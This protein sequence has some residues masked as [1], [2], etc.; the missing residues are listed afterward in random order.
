MNRL[1]PS[2]WSPSYPGYWLGPILCWCMLSRLSRDLI[3]GRSRDTNTALLLVCLLSRDT[4]P[5]VS[6]APRSPV[7]VGTRHHVT[8]LKP[9][10]PYVARG[11]GW[12][13]RPCLNPFLFVCLLLHCS[14]GAIIIHIICLNSNLSIGVSCI[15]LLHYLPM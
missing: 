2:Y 11:D 15:I 6:L 1:L 3:S 4:H 8:F 10:C 13:Y 5:V 7:L 14:N 12:L 9:L